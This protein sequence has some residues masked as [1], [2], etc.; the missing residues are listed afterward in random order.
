MCPINKRVMS[1][2]DDSQVT[3]NAD[4]RKSSGRGIRGMTILIDK[5]ARHIDCRLHEWDGTND[6]CRHRQQAESDRPKARL[7]LQ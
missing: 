6:N 4:Y 2:T 3:N 5:A 1:F 7:T